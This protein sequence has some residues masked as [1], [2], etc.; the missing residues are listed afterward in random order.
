M[1]AEGVAL[2][3]DLWPVGAQGH[4]ELEIL[5]EG[6]DH[7]DSATTAT[8]TEVPLPPYRFLRWG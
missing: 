8:P 7:G 1:A 2:P 4:E 5:G 3:Q 6:G